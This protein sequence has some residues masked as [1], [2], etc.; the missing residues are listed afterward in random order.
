VNQLKAIEPPLKPSEITRQRLDLEEAIRRVESE[1]ANAALFARRSASAPAPEVTAGA[2]PTAPAV[3][4]P[5]P[6]RREPEPRPAPEAPRPEAPAAAAEE[7][8]FE[9]APMPKAEAPKEAD[10]FVADDLHQVVRAAEALG[11]ASRE[12]ARGARETLA[13]LDEEAAVE[14]RI[15]PR[16]EP[17]AP[18]AEASPPHPEKATR[19][20]PVVAEEPGADADDEAAFEEAPIERLPDSGGGTL[21][22]LIL[23]L[24]VLLVGVGVIGWLQRDA[25]FGPSSDPG[26]EQQTGAGEATDKPSASGKIEDRLPQDGVPE[27][28][29]PADSGPALPPAKDDGAAATTDAGPATAAAPDSGVSASLVAQRSILYEE[30][31]P[32][33]PE[34]GIALAGGVTWEV[35]RDDQS[36]DPVIRARIEVP[37]RGLRVIL[38]IRRNNDTALPASHLVE[39][40]FDFPADFPGQGIASVPGLILKASEQERGEAL[41]GAAAKVADGFF[42]IALS[43]TEED[44]KKNRELLTSQTWFDIPLMYQN[45]RRAILT[46]EKGVPGERA[47]Q[48]AFAAWGE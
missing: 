3:E 12:A 39:M 30:A 15:E 29:K 19:H 14:T 20:T 7:D 25:L 41:R 47:F 46:L 23:I 8:V 4:P 31:A 32:E 2:R 37:D 17:P 5:A 21:K 44:R 34:K 45:G 38:T 48:E 9:P 28:Q 16:M 42:W 1:A 13:S 10:K 35:G 43:S 22:F 33:D 40:L 11:G 6:P 18:K 27:T 24:V 26:T 36:S